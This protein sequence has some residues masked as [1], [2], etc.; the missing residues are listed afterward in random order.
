MLTERDPV[1]LPLVDVGDLV[2]VP[3]NRRT[4]GRLKDVPATNDQRP[5][6]IKKQK[7]GGD[8]IIGGF[9][10]ALPTLIMRRSSSRSDATSGGSQTQPQA[11]ARRFI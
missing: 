10:L 9:P 5:R 7:C 8:I 11:H 1:E 4:R 2:V 6:V 3:A